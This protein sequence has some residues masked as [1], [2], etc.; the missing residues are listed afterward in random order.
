MDGWDFGTK[1]LRLGMADTVGRHGE[2]VRGR[3]VRGGILKSIATCFPLTSN[4]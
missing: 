3:K 1:I 4:S 2:G